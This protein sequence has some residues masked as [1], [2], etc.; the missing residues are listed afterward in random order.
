MSYKHGTHG[1]VNGHKRDGSPLCADCTIAD[2]RY[3]AIWRRRTDLGMPMKKRERPDWAHRA[4]LA[5][6]ALVGP[7][8]DAAWRANA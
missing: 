6:A 1:G 2:A 7:V 4:E 3:M 5:D 8:L